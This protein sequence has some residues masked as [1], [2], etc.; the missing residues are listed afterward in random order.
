MSDPITPPHRLRFEG[1]KSPLP[2]IEEGYTHPWDVHIRGM[3][4]P[5]D[6]VNIKGIYTPR[7]VHTH[8][9]H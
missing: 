8:I 5:E 3:Y 1:G 4:A 7:D 6:D 9:A 2:D